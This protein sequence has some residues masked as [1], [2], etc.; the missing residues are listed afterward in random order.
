MRDLLKEGTVLE[1]SEHSD[2]KYARKYRI[3]SFVDEGGSS[4]CY[5][6]ICEDTKK[7]GKLKEYYPE[8]YASL[9]REPE[10]N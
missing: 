3:I 4:V 2:G 1:L 8:S 5:E 9:K 7:I 10:S 6:A